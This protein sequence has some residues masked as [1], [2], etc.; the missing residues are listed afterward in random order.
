MH[1]FVLE[2]ADSA[3]WR[4]HRFGL[5][6]AAWGRLGT[7]VFLVTGGAS[8]FGRAIAIALALAG[9]RVWIA[10]RRP[11][12]FEEVVRTIRDLRPDA[13]RPQSL[14]LDLARPESIEDCAQAL[15]ART[16]ELHGLV[17]S[18]ALPQNDSDPRPLENGD[19][20][21]WRS[22]LSVNLEG[23]WLLTRACLA[24][25]RRAGRGRVLCLSS[26][27]GWNG[28]AGFGFY[29][30]SKAALN[31]LAF[32]FA[33][34]VAASHGDFDFQLNVLVPG[35]AHSDMNRA[36]TVSPFTAVSMGLLLLSQGAGGPNGYFF[37]RDGRHLGFGDRGPYG[38]QL[39]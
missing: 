26:Q 9:A 19:F 22:M 34:E 16:G 2:A 6:P 14:P 24:S 27:A 21:D 11:D 15:A 4:A 35:E 12:R 3:D 18:A 10:T 29:N 20:A 7:G 28:T 32:S 31:S 39:S 23:P 1:S 33:E 8:G 5:S 37:H 13:T 25:M 38:R 30:V 17:H 36:S